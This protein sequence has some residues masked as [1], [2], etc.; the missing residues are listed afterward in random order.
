MALALVVPLA[1][2]LATDHP[3]AGEWISLTAESICWVELKGSYGQRLRVLAGGAFLAFLFALLGSLTAP[4]LWLSV[5]AMLVVGFISGLFKN[6]GDRGSGLSICVYVM[7]IIANAAAPKDSAELQQRMEWVAI[8]GGWNTIVG[9]VATAFMPEQQP[10][11]RS[12]A[13][14]WR[15]ISGLIASV[16]KGWDGKGVRSSIREVYLKEKEVRAA[17]DSSLQLYESMA[18]QV[19]KK[20][21]RIFE[22]AQL[23]KATSLVATHIIAMGEE[24]EGVDMRSIESNLRLK[25]YALFKAMQQ[26]VERMAVYVVTLQPEE[27]L[28]LES[29]IERLHKLLALLREYPDIGNEELS[30]RI[31]RLIQLTE[32]TIRILER[33]IQRLEE[34][35]AEKPAF[36]SYSL[37]KTLFVLH[38]R[39]WLRNL[40][41]LLDFNTFTTRYALRTALAA[42]LG[43]FIFK[44]FR[45]DHGY[46]F[47]FTIILVIQPYF[48]ATFKKAIDRVIGTVSGVIVGSLLL[49]LPSGLHMKE[50]MLAI[51]A[52]FMVYYIRRQYSV[53]A[54]FI[55]LSLVLLFAVGEE[56]NTTLIYTRVLCTVGGAALAVLAGFALLPT[57]DKKQLP[58]HLAD[59]LGSN[60][61]YFSITF[62]PETEHSSWTRY[63]R[64]AETCN[65]NAFDSF[66][67]YMQEPSIRKKSYALYY[68]L[69]T[70]SVRLT[71]ELNNI[72]LEQENSDR[73][74]IQPAT[75]RQSERIQECLRLLNK[76]ILKV[77]ERGLLPKV[78]L[79]ALDEQYLGPF[80][81][82]THQQIYLDKMI[83]ELKAMYRD[84]ERLVE[85]E[86]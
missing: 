46:W 28:L 86:T 12:I 25:L 30:R 60:Y 47:P 80:L 5:G 72:N 58:R 45:I 24:M 54:F 27:E 65:S 57:W 50:I 35:G 38:P 23:R 64:N 67:R 85:R 63:K 48:G 37:L 9:M 14:I 40:R 68:Q 34:L 84:L 75:P 33:S 8:G 1:W 31:G 32:R 69:I 76:A 36:R 79:I 41:L 18:H 13:L 20:Q 39:H 82:T 7:F 51:C 3:H 15:A 78:K 21:G 66:N 71:R 22:L 61:Q 44:W 52:F 10:Y 19:S 70:H 11:R 59:A 77:R 53:A 17:I 56:L 4:Y 42:T 49:R 29:R 26:T 16:T 74:Q 6:L 2:G 62:F 73:E 83:I 43:L 81:L 55:T